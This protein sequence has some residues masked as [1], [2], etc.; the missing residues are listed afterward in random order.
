[1]IEIVLVGWTKDLHGE[2]LSI[3]TN[4]NGSCHFVQILQIHFGEW[5]SSQLQN[6]DYSFHG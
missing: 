4:E 6:D 2:R 3:S 1:M 5:T